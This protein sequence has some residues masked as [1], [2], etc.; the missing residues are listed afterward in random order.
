MEMAGLIL[1]TAVVILLGWRQLAIGSYWRGYFGILLVF[2]GFLVF[3]ESFSV[4]FL[5]LI[6]GVL[7]VG[8]DLFF[9]APHRGF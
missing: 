8:V 3:V 1:G 2:A 7:A 4:L 6:I 5:L 9:V